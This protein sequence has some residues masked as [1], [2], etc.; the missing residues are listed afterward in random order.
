MFL[1]STITKSFWQNSSIP[2]VVKEPT[3]IFII[4]PSGIIVE[5]LK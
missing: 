5:S 4:I 2:L 3:E 1:I